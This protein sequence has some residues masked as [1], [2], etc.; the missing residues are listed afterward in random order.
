MSRVVVIGATGHIG[1]YLVPRLARDGHEVVAMSR[2]IRGPYLD[3]PGGTR[4][5]RSP[6]TGTRPMPRD[7]SVRRWRRCAPM[8]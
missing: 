1:S 8:W 2:G 4:S 3:S 6:W 7:R 5:P